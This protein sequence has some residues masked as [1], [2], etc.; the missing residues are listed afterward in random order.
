MAF[1]SYVFV[2][3][4]D[5][6]RSLK[7]FRDDVNGSLKLDKEDLRLALYTWLNKWGCRLPDAYCAEACRQ[8]GA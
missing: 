8:I 6:D 4:T 2:P 7:K 3:M 1:T 5:Y